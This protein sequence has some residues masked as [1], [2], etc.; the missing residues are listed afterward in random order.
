MVV[1]LVSGFLFFWNLHCVESDRRP[2]APAQR[3]SKEMGV[4]S[5]SFQM[6]S[7]LRLGGA[8]LRGAGSGWMM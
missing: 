6:E 2:G 1:Y 7:H 4:Q 3:Q 8:G 5:A